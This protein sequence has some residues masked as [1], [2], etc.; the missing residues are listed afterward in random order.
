MILKLLLI[1]QL[2]SFGFQHL[3]VPYSPYEDLLMKDEIS[4]LFEREFFQYK[5]KNL[6]IDF[7][8]RK[9]FVSF[10][11]TR[12]IANSRLNKVSVYLDN[13]K[14]L[15]MFKFFDYGKFELYEFPAE[16]S[17]I[18]YNPFGVS[19]GVSRN[20]SISKEFPFFL[21]IFYNEEKFLEKKAKNFSLNFNLFINVLKNP[22]FEVSLINLGTKP[23][24]NEEYIR[25]PVYSDLKVYLYSRKMGTMLNFTYRR[26][27]WGKKNFFNGLSLSFEKEFKDFLKFFTAICK[28]DENGMLGVGFETKLKEIIKFVY[29][30]RTFGHFEDI[31][32]F[33]LKIEF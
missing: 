24:Y 4:L 12:W 15:L 25:L 16:N 9:S 5:K 32:S 29:S 11:H 33:S 14:T 30:Y 22:K 13:L 8:E 10:S 19:V 18:T 27:F 2:S 3:F 7:F 17:I 21:S 23:L 20:F 1:S 6:I 28:K 31:N 26:G